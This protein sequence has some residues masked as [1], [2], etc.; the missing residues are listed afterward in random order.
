MNPTKIDRRKKY[1][2][3]VDTETCNGIVTETGQLDLSCSIVYDFGLAVID[4]KGNVYETH[5]FVIRESFFGMHDV[6]K[7]AYYAEKIPQYRQDIRNKTRQVVSFVEAKLVLRD[8][9]E[10]YHTNAP[11]PAYGRCCPVWLPAYRCPPCRPPG[12]TC[13]GW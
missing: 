3:V 4:K 12:R 13:P 6:M 9:M 10:K 8:I 11:R 1:I 7:T 5:S 2:I